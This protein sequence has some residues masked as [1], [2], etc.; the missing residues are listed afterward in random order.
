MST[1]S[2]QQNPTNCLLCL[3]TLYPYHALSIIGIPLSSSRKAAGNAAVLLQF[4]LKLQS[5]LEQEVPIHSYNPE[6]SQALFIIL[7]HHMASE[8]S[9]DR[10][11]SPSKAQIDKFHAMK[12]DN[13]LFIDS[14]GGTI[15]RT[16]AKKCSS[17]CMHVVQ[18]T[19]HARNRINLKKQT[20]SLLI[21][22]EK[23]VQEYCHLEVT[24]HRA[25]RL[26]IF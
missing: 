15:D 17:T 10:R 22:W 25:G 18:Y 14:G 16:L 5:S 19:S 2:S 21:R 8:T 12:K 7:R 20:I 24:Y 1:T 9:E 11:K 13:T 26:P 6:E 23:H 3:S 4:V